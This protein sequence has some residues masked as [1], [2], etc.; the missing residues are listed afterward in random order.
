M[1]TIHTLASGSSGNA[2]LVSCGG[3]HILVDAG[4]SCRRIGA[5]LQALG[6]QMAD[7]SAILITHTHSDHI[8][9][10]GTLC[11]RFR[12]PLYASPAACGELEWRLQAQKPELRPVTGGF[13][14][15][16]VSVTAF[17][18]AHDAPG[19][20]GYRIGPVG[21]LTDT[22]YVTEEA[23]QALEGVSLLVLEANHDVET[24]RSGTYPYY[25]KQRIL[26]SRG[27]LSNADAARF[28]RRCAE[29][30]TRQIL[31]AHLSRENNTPAMALAAV[32]QALSGLD[33]ALAVV[34][35]EELSPAYVT[36][37]E[38]LCRK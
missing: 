10:L 7:L 33:T 38:T 9:G 23:E 20:Q 24:L 22:G 36:E 34:P 14:V 1:T 26:G 19:S 25:L 6:L 12:I 17:P 31:L 32:E 29:T 27:H 8:Q 16:G 5:G 18:T 30:G 13:A 4:I 28:A 21:F 2:A 11:K 35:R 15:E 3:V 37:E